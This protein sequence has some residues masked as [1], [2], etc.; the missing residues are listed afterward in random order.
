MEIGIDIVEVK[1]IERLIKDKAFLAR[2][3]TLQEI[4]YCSSKKIKA[5][6]FAVRFATKEAVWKAICKNGIALKDIEVKNLSNG[7]PVVLIKNTPAKN[8][9]I[10]LTHTK[11][12]AAA[13]AVVKKTKTK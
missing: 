4:A 3:Y 2:V 5:Q 9:S 8:I 10:S 1:R 7:K 13:V 12:Y 6:H 11:N